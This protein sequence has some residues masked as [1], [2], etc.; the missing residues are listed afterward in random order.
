ME[1]T[2]RKEIIQQLR[3]K[4]MVMEGFK[5]NSMET[6]RPDFGLDGMAS[7]F[8]QGVFPI[9]AVHEF[10]SPTA[11][12]ATASNGFISGI[13][14]TLM[15]D[16]MQCL[17]VSTKRS[18]SP[19]ALTLFGVPPHQVIFVDVLRDRD[20]LWVMEQG[21]KC[22]ALAA[23]VAELGEVSFAESQ[24]LQLAVEKSRV[25][26][27]L[28]RRRPRRQHTLSCVARWRVKPV[29]SHA[30][31]GLPGVGHPVWEVQLEKIRNGKPGKWRF[32]WRKEKF[33]YLPVQSMAVS[34]ASETE[35]Y[36]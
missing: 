19:A 2:E 8:P 31:D 1:N 28:H 3:E 33:V 10:V 32:G 5:G 11:S 16:G 35:R 14:S 20:V 6:D 36:A 26:G 23:V 24:R 15:R 9:G 30:S 7:A 17:W 25:T 34:A 18:L 21:L 13:L 29:E 4:I 22:D 12:C 27:F